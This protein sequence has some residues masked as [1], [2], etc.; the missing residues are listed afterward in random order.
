M[1]TLPPAVTA[2]T[3]L[4]ALCQ[5]VESL[6]SVSATDVS[7]ELAREAIELAMEHLIPATLCPKP[8]HREGMCRAANLAGRAINGTRTTAC[9]ALSYA[10][11]SN[12]GLPHGI[13]VALTLA[14]ML[15]FNWLV[16]DDDCTDPRGAEAVRSRIKLILQAMKVDTIESA[17]LKIE[18]LMQQIGCPI[19]LA[20]AGIFSSSD[21]DKII[22]SVNVQRMSNNPRQTSPDDLRALLV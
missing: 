3:G 12:H 21:I 22:Q 5:A 14:P 15:R 17:C 11:T 8:I 1:Q 13:A 20:E 9:H 19:T 16:S 18:H 10:M 2:A 7:V 6:W 4:D